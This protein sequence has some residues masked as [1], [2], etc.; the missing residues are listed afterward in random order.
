MSSAIMVVA[1]KRAVA[2]TEAWRQD[3]GGRLTPVNGQS[4]KDLDL[5]SWFSLY[6]PRPWF[7]FSGAAGNFLLNKHPGQHSCGAS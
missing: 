4:Y 5:I 6:D 2:L 1:C 7:R 3:R